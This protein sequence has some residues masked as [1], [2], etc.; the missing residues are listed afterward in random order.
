[1][2][3]PNPAFADVDVPLASTFVLSKKKGKEAYVEPVIE[4]GGYRFT[5][6]AGPPPESEK[7]GTKMARGG[8]FRCVVSNTPIPED[9][10]RAEGQAGRMGARLMAV[11][12]EGHRARLYLD[13]SAEHELVAQDADAKWRPALH[14]PGNRRWF[15]PPL[16]GLESFG[17]LFTDRQLVALTTFSDLVTEA[18]ERVRADALAAGIP[19][20]GVPLRDGG[21]GAT[22]YA[23][24]V[25]VVPSLLNQ[26]RS[27][28]GHSATS[29][30]RWAKLAQERTGCVHLFGR[31]AIPMIMGL[32]RRSKRVRAR[33]AGDYLSQ[34]HQPMHGEG[35]RS[36]TDIGDFSGSWLINL[37]HQR[38]ACQLARER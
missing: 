27:A 6:R 18:R 19:D 11:V 34:K 17:D 30:C 10:I 32:S 31:Q 24:A 38:S 29:L 37:M 25:G 13:P 5:V 15:S 28:H 8:N 35:Y 23:E 12:A 4:D 16:Y 2:K 26:L 22:G 7:Q 33:P 20:D 14:M 36:V 1:M 21:V 3:S 9:Y